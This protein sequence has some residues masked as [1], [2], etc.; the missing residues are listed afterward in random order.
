M[1]D[2]GFARRSLLALLLGG[3]ISLLAVLAVLRPAE[4]A[5]PESKPW[6]YSQTIAHLGFHLYW[7]D[8]FSSATPDASVT[9]YDVQYRQQGDTT[10]L[11]WTHTGTVRAVAFSGLTAGQAYQV[12]IRATNSDGNGPWS[13]TEDVPAVASHSTTVDPPFPLLVQAGDAQATVTWGQP[14]HTGGRTLTGYV[15]RLYLGNVATELRSVTVSGATTTSTVISGLT[16]D[17]AYQVAMYA[18]YAVPG[19]VDGGGRPTARTQAFTPSAATQSSDANLSNLTG[20]TS[21]DGNTFSG[22]LSLSPAFNAATTGYTATVA[23]TVTHAK[24]TPTRSHSAATI[25]VN[26]NAV[27]SGNASAAIALSVGGNNVITVQVTAEDTTTTKSYTVTITRQGAGQSSDATL[28]ALT[29]TPCTDSTTCTGSLAL[30]PAF[31]AATTGYTATVANTITHAKL[32]PTTSHSAATVTVNGNAVTSGNASAAI[33]LN[34]GSNNVITVQVTAEDTTTTKSYTVTITR[35]GAGQSSDATLS[36]LT[37]TPCTDSTTC[38][39]SLALSPAFNAAT[40]GYT[41]TVANTITHAKLTPTRSHSAATITVNGNAVT[42]GNA[43]AA[44]ALNVGSNNVITV[45]VTAQD[46]TTKD[47]TVTITRQGPAQSSD[48]TLSALAGTPCTSST[49]CSGALSLSPAFNAATTGYTATVA[50]NITHAKLTPTRSHSAAT[51]TVNGNAV[52]SGN[53][54]A[55]IALNVGSSNVITV[56]VTA[57]DSTTKDYTVTIT[58]QGPAQSSDATLSALTG[59]PCTDSTTCSGALAL[60]PAFNAATTGYTATVA[61]T[62]THATLTPTVNH[63]AATVTVNGMAVNSG[64]PSQAIALSVG[65]NAVAVRVT[66]EDSTTRAYTVTITRLAIQVED[67]S[68]TLNV[69]QAGGEQRGLP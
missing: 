29:G 56:R 17:T 39:G 4:A 63:S 43:S 6:I 55:A 42:S 1:S 62:I 50:N 67:W 31:N 34:V 64:A 21:T 49:S 41:A 44:I 45:R 22:T 53:A 10:W 33:A 69:K 23:N 12:R 28:S 27:T 2:G 32:T 13:L 66:A 8:G 26:G 54:S 61:N 35:Q 30:S 7:W 58:R 5:A 40:T 57:Q 9:G 25:T 46:S 3:A 38:T 24:L 14:S 11:D 59:T 36:A 37:G 48:A 47:Y 20:T 65:A 60:S 51:I 19:N 68:T 52:T 18:T 15:V 16:N